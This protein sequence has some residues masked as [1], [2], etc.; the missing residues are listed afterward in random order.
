[1]TLTSQPTI[2]M[3]HPDL[4]KRIELATRPQEF[5]RD[6]TLY[7]M[8]YEQAQRDFRR[9]LYHHMNKPLPEQLPKVAEDVHKREWYENDT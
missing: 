9:L 8:G 1:M 3:I 6:S 4:L 7:D 2:P 5:G